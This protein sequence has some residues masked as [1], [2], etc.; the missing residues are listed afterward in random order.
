MNKK[1]NNNSTKI[2]VSIILMIISAIL[3]LTGGILRIV[4]GSHEK[5]EA[6]AFNVEEF[7]GDGTT[8]ALGSDE[9]VYMNEMV[10][11]VTGVHT[12]IENGYDT[13]VYN[14]L[15]LSLDDQRYLTIAIIHRDELEIY[16]SD[17]TCVV[18][19]IPM[20][21]AERLY[22][23]HFEGEMLKTDF[24]D[25]LSYDEELDLIKLNNCG[26]NEI[27][28]VHEYFYDFASENNMYFA[29]IAVSFDEDVNESNYESFKHYMYSF[30]KDENNNLLFQEMLEL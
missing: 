14:N 28:S 21:D 5:K 6:K 3:I 13:D 22:N 26:N 29:Y 16:S 9:E 8:R 24:K 23:K 2:N 7:D 12:L 19:T 4:M 18:E 15:S 1:S 11:F 27:D 30:M 25:P 17:D 20:F 10:S